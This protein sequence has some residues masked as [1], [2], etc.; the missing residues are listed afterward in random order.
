MGQS[1]NRIVRNVVVGFKPMHIALWKIIEK[2]YA[3]MRK[4][5]QY[6]LVGSLEE[7]RAMLATILEQ[8]SE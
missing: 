7:A 3:V 6:F 1:H 4:S 5:Q 2:I 8:K